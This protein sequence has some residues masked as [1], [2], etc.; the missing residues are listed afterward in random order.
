MKNKHN[1][2]FVLVA[3]LVV[4]TSAISRVTHSESPAVSESGYAN[5]IQ[6]TPPDNIGVILFVNTCNV[7]LE[8]KWTDGKDCKNWSCEEWVNALAKETSTNTPPDK[9]AAC[10][11]PITPRIGSNG[12]YGC[13]PIGTAPRTED[14]ASASTSPSSRTSPH[15]TSSSS[16]SQS[17]AGRVTEEPTQGC[18]SVDS[19]PEYGLR[20]ITNRCTFGLNLYV[21][22]SNL[23]IKGCVTEL[24]PNQSTA[25]LLVGTVAVVACTRELAPIAQQTAFC[26]KRLT[27]QENASL[28]ASVK[29]MVAAAQ[30]ARERIAATRATHDTPASD[31]PAKSDSSGDCFNQWS[32]AVDACELRALPSGGT[33][34]AS[35]G[36]ACCQEANAAAT[37]SCRAWAQTVSCQ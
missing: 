4:I 24:D 1:L 31:S 20:K 36:S 19:L 7:K 27:P 32:R 3:V 12:R 5:C 33:V 23:C 25:L 9:I 22:D 13:F 10:R 37:G 14:D 2:S 6:V 28:Q 16:S 26:A 29:R 35:L 18:I 11:W 8:V 30:V 34:S 21:G 17:L 15:A